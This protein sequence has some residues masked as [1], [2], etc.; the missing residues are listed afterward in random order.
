MPRCES[1]Q[2][3]FPE[4]IPPT[5]IVHMCQLFQSPRFQAC[6]ALKTLPSPDPSGTGFWVTR[7]MPLEAE[8][9]DMRKQHHHILL[10]GLLT[11][12]IM[13]STSGCMF[14]TGL[15]RAFNGPRPTLPSRLERTVGRKYA[16]NWVWLVHRPNTLQYHRHNCPYVDVAAN[17]W[18]VTLG[19]ARTHR[20][21]PCGRCNP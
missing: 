19:Y 6:A 10:V 3:Q 8:V 7:F 14:I 12:L 5:F 11:A 18:N 20:Y 1:L 13:A 16:E 2:T 4:I 15:E 21:R 17:P 9:A